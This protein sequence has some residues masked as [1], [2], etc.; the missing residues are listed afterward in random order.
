MKRFIHQNY[1]FAFSLERACQ[2]AIQRGN[3]GYGSIRTKQMRIQYFTEFLKTSGIKDLRKVRYADLQSFGEHVAQLVKTQNWSTAYAQNILSDANVLMGFV[4][5]QRSF[6]IR[7][8]AYVGQRG[9]TRS[10]P[11][12]GMSMSDIEQCAHALFKN[13]DERAGL[14]LLMARFFG[15]RLQE[16]VKAD[17]P[18]LLRQAKREGRINILEGTKGG[19]K[20][21]RLLSVNDFGIWILQ[22]AHDLAREDHGHCLIPQDQNYICFIRSEIARARQVMKTCGIKGFH[23]L[24]SAYSCD[25]YTQIAGVPAPVFT[26]GRTTRGEV[27]HNARMVISTEL[28][29]H[30]PEVANSYIGA[31]KPAPEF[32]DIDRAE[33][34]RQKREMAELQT[35]VNEASL[36]YLLRSTFKGPKSEY[37]IHLR[38]VSDM[39]LPYCRAHAVHRLGEITLQD[40]QEMVRSETIEHGNRSR[41]TQQ[42]YLLSLLRFAHALGHAEWELPIREAAGFVK[43]T[44]A[45][46]QLKINRRLFRDNRNQ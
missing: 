16:A 7:P 24:R 27:D 41:K 40:L 5:H 37:R 35:P 31:R 33:Q 42:D 20:V 3:K 13:G 19:R 18:R 32:A 22:Q 21:A 38:R 43:K 46:R 15:M 36:S 39:L 25:R 4:R 14:I 28:G 30:R 8:C 11:P 6:R 34:T 10:N 12:T 23:D 17:L 1:G 26:G 2:I 45:G 9:W 44:Q 29:H